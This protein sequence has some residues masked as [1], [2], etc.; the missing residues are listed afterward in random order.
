MSTMAHLGW[1]ALHLPPVWQPDFP[2]HEL[3]QLP[4]HDRRGHCPAGHQPG[5][6]PLCRYRARLNSISANTHQ[7][8]QSPSTS[9]LL[10]L[11]RA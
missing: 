8:K 2:G 4:G 9:G 11:P 7:P 5:P 10:P 3:G 1:V 6:V